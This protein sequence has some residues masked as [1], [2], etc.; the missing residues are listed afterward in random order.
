MLRRKRTDDGAVE[1]DQRNRERAPC[2]ARGRRLLAAEQRADGLADRAHREVSSPHEEEQEERGDDGADFAG[3]IG[4][5]AREQRAEGRR[6]CCTH[7]SRIHRLE[8]WSEAAFGHGPNGALSLIPQDA[9]ARC[10]VDGLPGRR[11]VVM[12]PQVLALSVAIAFVVAGCGGSKRRD[13]P[14]E[15]PT[16]TAGR[17]CSIRGRHDRPR[18]GRA[19]HRRRASRRAAPRSKTYEREP[20]AP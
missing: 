8:R 16:E 10:A 6:C 19:A 20:D 4:G 7:R 12:H 17:A 1:R 18:G 3:S 2:R 13:E 11:R 15:P 14:A 9:D 5:E